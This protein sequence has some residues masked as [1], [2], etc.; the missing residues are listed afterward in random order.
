MLKTTCIHPQIIAALALCGHGDKVLIADGNFPL[1]TYCKNADC[2][3]LGITKGTPRADTVLEALVDIANFEK[4]EVMVPGEGEKPPIF[5]EFQEILQLKTMDGLG[6]Y[7][8]Y[9]ACENQVKL[10]ISTG[11]ER[12]FG[13]VLL[14]VGTC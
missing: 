6:R 4:A 13:N 3:Y 2:V 10:A 9:E 14:T 5:A 11:E 1:S 12:L 8:F 7:A